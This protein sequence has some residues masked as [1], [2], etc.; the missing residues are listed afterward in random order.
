MSALREVISRRPRFLPDA[1]AG[2][3]ILIYCKCVLI[4]SIRRRMEAHS[5]SLSES[6][7]FQ[8]TTMMGGLATIVEI[9]DIA[10]PV[11]FFPNFIWHSYVYYSY[12]MMI[13]IRLQTINHHISVSTTH[14]ESQ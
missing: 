12:T 7:K 4:S 14:T 3:G 9:A 13:I 11:K 10:S 8:A 5:G 2:P 1:Q 6:V